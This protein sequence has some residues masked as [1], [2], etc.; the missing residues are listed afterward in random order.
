MSEQELIARRAN[1]QELFTEKMAENA[2]AGQKKWCLYAQNCLDDEAQLDAEIEEIF[3]VHRQL[4][5]DDAAEPDRSEAM[6]DVMAGRSRS[7]T[8]WGSRAIDSRTGLPR[9]HLPRPAAR[10]G[11]GGAQRRGEALPC[12]GTEGEGP[13]DEHE[14]QT[15]DRRP[16][17]HRPGGRH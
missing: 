3:D 5:Q 8:E 16:N 17:V 9:L 1:E 4:I 13:S 7:V 14:D 11:D 6:K 10:T 2:N 12:A 15:A